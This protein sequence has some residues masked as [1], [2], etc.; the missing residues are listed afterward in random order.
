MPAN[1]TPLVVWIV[2]LHQQT[3]IPQI[4]GPNSIDDHISQILQIQSRIMETRKRLVEGKT[5][6]FDYINT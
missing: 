3:K 2:S 1:Q 5:S 4:L 6:K